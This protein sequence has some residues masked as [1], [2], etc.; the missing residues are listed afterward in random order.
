MQLHGVLSMKALY[1]LFAK[2]YDNKNLDKCLYSF[3]KFKNP[4]TMSHNIAL[5]SLPKIIKSYYK[6]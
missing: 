2:I 3:G 1:K 5:Q 6:N 4:F